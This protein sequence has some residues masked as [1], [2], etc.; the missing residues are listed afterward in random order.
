MKTALKKTVAIA[1][2]LVTWQALSY[3]PKMNIV[4]PSPIE[5]AKRFA[6]IWQEPSFFS[7]IGFTLKYTSLGFLIGLLFGCGLA[8]LASRFE[9]VETLLWPYVSIIK[10][11]PVASFIVLIFC[12][13]VIWFGPWSL[14]CAI[15]ALM[16]FPIMYTSTLSGIRSIDVGLDKMA[17]VYK[18]PFWKKLLY[19][20]LPQI[21]SHFLSGCTVS[22]GLCWKSGI[23]AEVIGQTSASIGGEIFNAKFAFDMPAL[24]CWTIIIV[25]I[26]FAFEKLVLWSFGCLFK[27]LERLP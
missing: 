1:I 9:W 3:L 19:V 26:S 16:V 11:V 10:S 8:I 12:T 22:L 18:I 21:K 23:A 25:L 24:F 2:A 7:A 14:S 4:L 15:A 13:F 5:V 6:T 27:R 20:K 17:L